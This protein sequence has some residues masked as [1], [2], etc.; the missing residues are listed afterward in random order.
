MRVPSKSGR[1]A[2]V[3]NTC[4]HDGAP[5]NGREDYALLVFSKH[6]L[7]SRKFE[8]ITSFSHKFITDFTG[9]DN[10]YAS[11]SGRKQSKEFGHEDFFFLVFSFPHDIHIY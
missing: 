11:D 8:H 5:L 4:K 9:K 3:V 1:L 6:L 2:K 7:N 10:Y